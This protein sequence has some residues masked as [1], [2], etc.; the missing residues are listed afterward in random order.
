MRRAKQDRLA[1][2]CR[3]G[4]NGRMSWTRRFIW[5]LWIFLGVLLC[6]NL[7]SCND[8]I[9][10]EAAKPK[11]DH[12]FFYQPTKESAAA[13]SIPEGPRVEQT[14]FRVEDNAPSDGAYTCHVTLK[15]T[16]KSKAINVQVCVRP[17]RGSVSGGADDSG[18]NVSTPIPD[19]DPRAQINQWLAFP[20]LDP[21][22]SSTQSIV[23][24]KVS[25]APNFGNNPKPEIVFRPEKKK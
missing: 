4:Y 25:N 3:A 9:A 21:G 1:P 5:T 13:A 17:F 10:T 22:Q 14:G 24:T 19:D 16:G 11:Q 12:F 20:D 15:N 23:F 2:C 8:K 18:P 6:W 7:Y